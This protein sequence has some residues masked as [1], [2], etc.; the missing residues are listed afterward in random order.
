MRFGQIRMMKRVLRKG[1][2]GGVRN[3][4]RSARNKSQL[5]YDLPVKRALGRA[6]GATDPR[7]IHRTV[8]VP[9]RLGMERAMG[10]A[11]RFYELDGLFPESLF[12][13]SCIGFPC[14]RLLRS[15]V[16]RQAAYHIRRVQQRL[17]WRGGPGFGAQHEGRQSQDNDKTQIKHPIPPHGKQMAQNV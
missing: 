3:V 12:E 13:R 16:V 8:V 9:Y 10:A 4:N 2:R 11:V 14:D 6:G 5:V 1:Y 15:V 7:F 17:C